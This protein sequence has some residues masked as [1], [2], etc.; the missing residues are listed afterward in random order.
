M[1]EW[2][3]RIIEEVDRQ[4]EELPSWQKNDEQARVSCTSNEGRSVST[5]KE[6]RYE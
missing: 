4:Y 6:P 1:A 3:E 2:L 5:A